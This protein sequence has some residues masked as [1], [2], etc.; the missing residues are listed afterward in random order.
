MNQE[1]QER[2]EREITIGLI[3]I[4]LLEKFYNDYRRLGMTEAEQLVKIAA[5]EAIGK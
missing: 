1:Q 5:I 2:K 3:Q 4:K